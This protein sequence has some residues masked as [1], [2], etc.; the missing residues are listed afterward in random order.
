MSTIGGYVV[1]IGEIL[2]NIVFEQPLTQYDF[3]TFFN[4][5]LSRNLDKNCLRLVWQLKKISIYT[6]T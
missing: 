4:R 1:K 6:S 2:I 3:K 5:G